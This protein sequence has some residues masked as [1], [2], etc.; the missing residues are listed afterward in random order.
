MD[1][2]VV[3]RPSALAAVFTIAVAC[4]PRE[5]PI[6]YLRSADYEFSTAD[7]A[8]IERILDAT[9]VEVRRILPSLPAQIEL[10]V[11]PG[12]DVI[13]ETGETAAATPP[14][15]V[16]WTVDPSR[17]GGVVKV[18]EDELRATLFHEFHHLVRWAAGSP[19]SIVEHAVFEG[20]ATVFERDFAGVDPPWGKYSEDVVALEKELLS[21]PGD[22]RVRDWLFSHPD[23]RRWIGIKVGAY[24]VDRAAAASKQT[25]ASL[26]VAPASEVLAMANAQK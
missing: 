24:W 1:M 17:P 19:R 5:V 25:S 16:V 7:R 9:T 12:A 13:A 15:G 2:A 21:L 6:R 18:A 11:R 14:A 26:A 22:A 23:G 4:A 8:T 20:M 3:M 10:T